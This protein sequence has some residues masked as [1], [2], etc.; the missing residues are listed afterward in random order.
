M[1][2][3]IVWH[4]SQ[5]TKDRTNLA[6]KPCILWFTGLSG[7]GR[8]NCANALKKYFTRIKTSHIF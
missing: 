8:V 6:Q 5:V 7:S 1:S 3:N 2:T 4:D